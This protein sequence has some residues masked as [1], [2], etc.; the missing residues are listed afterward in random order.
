MQLVSG[1]VESNAMSIFIA[2]AQLL[3]S[4]S[5]NF[6]ADPRISLSTLF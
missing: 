4:Q 1:K 2:V 5:M 6:S 3:L